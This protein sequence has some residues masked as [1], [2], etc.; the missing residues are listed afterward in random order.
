M[1]E[2]L[3]L[4]LSGLKRV[5]EGERDQSLNVKNTRQ[6]SQDALVWYDTVLSSLSFSSSSLLSL[7]LR[8]YNYTPPLP[9]PPP[10]PSAAAVVAVVVAAAAAKSLTQSSLAAVVAV[11][12]VVKVQA[13][14]T[15]INQ[16]L[17]VS[18]G[19]ALITQ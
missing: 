19:V 10:P 1:R 5:G 18:N 7:L 15:S 12:A 6:C 8:T 17:L 2:H 4:T 14:G 9:P 13:K 16:D 3:S 11:V